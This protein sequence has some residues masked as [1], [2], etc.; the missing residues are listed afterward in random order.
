MVEWLMWIG[1]VVAICTAIPGAVLMFVG[2]A[3]ENGKVYVIG[4]L[5]LAI[6]I[7]YCVVGLVIWLISEAVRLYPG[8]AA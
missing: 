3:I 1:L 4:F 8:G 6:T 2:G 5:G 7:G